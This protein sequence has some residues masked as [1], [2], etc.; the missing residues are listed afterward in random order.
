MSDVA[1]WLRDLLA[2]V[3]KETDVMRLIDDLANFC[4]QQHEALLTEH[5]LK[6]ALQAPHAHDCL[7]Q[8]WPSCV[9]LA[10]AEDF[11]EKIV[12]GGC[13]LYKLGQ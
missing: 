6:A 8:R 4:A 13:R 5:V 9:T 11:K 3:T 12:E 7:V 1:K 10:A 2:H